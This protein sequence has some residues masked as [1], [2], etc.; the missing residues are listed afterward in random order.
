[1]SLAVKR[2]EALDDRYDQALIS[3]KGLSTEQLNK[4]GHKF[5]P[6]FHDSNDRASLQQQLEKYLPSVARYAKAFMGKNGRSYSKGGLNM[7]HLADMIAVKPFELRAPE[8]AHLRRS[9]LELFGKRLS[10][11][12]Y[13]EML[14]NA[15]DGIADEAD[16]QQAPEQP[17]VEQ[18][19]L[20]EDDAAAPTFAALSFDVP[21]YAVPYYNDHG[22]RFGARRK[23]QARDHLKLM[24]RQS[25]LA[26][27]GNT[28]FVS[29]NFPLIAHGDE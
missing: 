12:R 2:L 27:C 29:Q 17:E 7:N 18:L 23:T 16:V 8:K 21:E 15:A 3:D 26:D 9:W 28:T 13:C 14:H 19:K 24:A 25:N 6:Y 10:A 20:E 1:M 11:E 5:L 22:P 4:V